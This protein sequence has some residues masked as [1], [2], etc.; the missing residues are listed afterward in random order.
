MARG[1]RNWT[2]KEVIRCLEKGFGFY[3]SHTRG[4]HLYYVKKAGKE[5]EK[6]LLTDVTYGDKSIH[7]KTMKSILGK[8]RIPEKVWLDTCSKK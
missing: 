5:G 7:P 6:D 3:H 2:Y 1:L 4:G 8:A